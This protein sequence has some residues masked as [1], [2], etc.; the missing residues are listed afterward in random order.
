MSAKRFNHYFFLIC[1]VLLLAA[2]CLNAIVV[3]KTIS[4]TKDDPELGWTFSGERQQFGFTLRFN[5]LGLRGG[6][7]PKG[8][9]RL[10]FLGNSV[11]MGQAVPEEKTFSALLGAVNA[12]LDGYDPYQME[13]KYRRDLSSLKPLFTGVVA[14]A[15]DVISREAG[16]ERIRQTRANNKT[17]QTKN[18]DVNLG[19][20]FSFSWK[21]FQAR[22][23]SENPDAAEAEAKDAGYFVRWPGKTGPNFRLT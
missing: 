17:V 11:T 4:I 23:R 18:L 15:N 8:P 2:V 7:L 14:V 21:E 19:R 20:Y 10:L 5:S 3:T 22:M 6:E 16:L 1:S 9:V 13:A 12:G